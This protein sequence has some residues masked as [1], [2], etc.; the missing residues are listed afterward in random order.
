M[1]IE[2]GAV[3]VSTPQEVY[4]VF[5]DPKFND[6]Y[7]LPGTYDFSTPSIT[8]LTF[9]SGKKIKFIG[10]VEFQNVRIRT[11]TL[12]NSD[13]YENGAS[14][15]AWDASDSFDKTG[16][17]DWSHTTGWQMFARD[18]WYERSGGTNTTFIP[19]IPFLGNTLSTEYGYCLCK[20]TTN[21]L[22]EGTLRLIVDDSPAVDSYTGAWISLTGI[23]FSE[24]INWRIDVTRDSGTALT[25]TSGIA[26]VAINSCA[27]IGLPEISV[28]HMKF[29][30]TAGAS[31]TGISIWSCNQLYSKGMFVGNILEDT[32][33]AGDLYGINLY[34]VNRS[35]FNNIIVSGFSRKS[36]G[37][38]D[39]AFGIM[40][41]D[42]N[43]NYIS[44][45]VAAPYSSSGSTYYSSE[46]GGSVNNTLDIVEEA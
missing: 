45:I 3:R 38:S 1:I 12:K 39:D 21:L 44:G 31:L 20:P 15:I 14:H 13:L 40:L 33:Q 8:D 46:S 25:G 37:A 30:P 35:K 5:E 22:V 4:D 23:A 28:T 32:A 27:A 18:A 24:L 16:G 19:V 41:N 11:E 29:T 6:I 34:Q 2:A 9:Y 26:A 17:T 43:S 7:I 36:G 10:I 42:C